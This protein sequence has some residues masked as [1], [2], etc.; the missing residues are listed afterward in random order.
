M[1]MLFFIT[2]ITCCTSD[3]QGFNLRGTSGTSSEVWCSEAMMMRSFL[4]SK[5]VL[6]RKQD[7]ASG[8]SAPKNV[9]MHGSTLRWTATGK[10]AAVDLEREARPELMM[11]CS[12]RLKGLLDLNSYLLNPT[13][14]TKRSSS[15][16]R[17]WYRPG[18]P[19][20]RFQFACQRAANVIVNLRICENPF[21]ITSAV[22]R[23]TV[24]TPSYP[25]RGHHIPF[26]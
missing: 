24:T 9:S 17:L 5:R 6:S 7:E 18:C 12:F 20:R 11:R 23:F 22:Q 13:Y 16:E 10:E 3:C 1:S 2:G 14:R 4:S 25:Q 15:I 19:K 21:R 8:S 26:S